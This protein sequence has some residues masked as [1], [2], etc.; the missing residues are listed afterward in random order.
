MTTD[1]SENLYF[2]GYTRS[3]DFPLQNQGGS[4]YY[5]AT[6]AGPAPFIVKF[7]PSGAR[8][9]STYYGDNGQGGALVT[10]QQG[11]LYVGGSTMSASFPTLSPGCGAFLKS[12][13]SGGIANGDIF[14]AQFD[15]VGTHFWGTYF[16]GPAD[17]WVDG[18]S[19]SPAGCVYLTGEWLSASG[20]NTLN[21]GGGAYFQPV[22]G[23]AQGPCDNGFILRFCPA[24]LTSTTSQTSLVCANDSNAVASVSVCGGSPPYTYT[25]STNPAKFTQ[26]VTNLPAG[27]YV[28]TIKDGSGNT[29]TTSVSIIAPGAVSV[30]ALSNTTIASG[31]TTTL[32]AI[33]NV[34]SY[35]WMPPAGLS[36]T[37][38]S[39]PSASPTITTVYTVV[40]TTSNNCRA[41]DMVT[42]TVTE[43]AEVC[44]DI[45]VPTG[46][47]P[48]GDGANDLECVMGHCITELHFEIY[49]RWGEKVFETTDQS[50]CWDGFKQGKLMDSG[51]F[52]YHLRATLKNGEQINKKGNLHLFR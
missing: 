24:P 48:N 50:K 31:E 35:T 49:D 23:G 46:F 47:T 22:L 18:L 36:A 41:S 6:A 43:P 28:V 29:F 32:S 3:A 1:L 15:S 19:V 8:V 45:F 17:E 25:W 16:G 26:T 13:Y 52:V 10:D 42:I 39:N 2:T 5:Q 33:G 27:N 4:A 7:R 9:W 20:I 11:N 34:V 21:P 14:I 30:S 38:I 12:G 44:G 51:V 40:A 37:N